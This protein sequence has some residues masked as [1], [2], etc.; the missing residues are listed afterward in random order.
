MACRMLARSFRSATKIVDA[1]TEW[2]VPC[3]AE[4]DLVSGAEELRYEMPSDKEGS[5]D[6][7][8]LLRLDLVVLAVR[9]RLGLGV[10][11]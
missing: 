5:T 7:Q 2:V 1:F 9:D 10:A 11:G 4:P 6:D 8:D 3:G